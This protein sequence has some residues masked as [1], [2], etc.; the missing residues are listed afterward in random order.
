M[1]GPDEAESQQ[2]GLKQA[3]DERIHIL[4]VDG[5]PASRAINSLALQGLGYRVTAV[6]DKF[7]ALES[8][9]GRPDDFDI[10]LI[11]VLPEPASLELARDLLSIRP[12]Q[13]IVLCAER[14][15]SDRAEEARS[16]GVREVVVLPF[17]PDELGEILE[18][19]RAK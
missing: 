12:A 10:V 16:V 1:P 5:E 15:D 8:F 19:A 13:R 17:S 7:E 6:P 3:L 9:S 18:R 11:G 14:M 2:K 4:F